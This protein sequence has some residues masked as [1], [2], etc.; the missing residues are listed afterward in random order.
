M[1]KTLSI[2]ALVLFLAIPASSQQILGGDI[3]WTCLNSGP[4][5]GKFVFQLTLF[6]QCDSGAVTATGQSIQLLNGPISNIPLNKLSD[7]NISIGCYD[8][9]KEIKCS[10]KGSGAVSMII[11]RSNPIQLSGTPPAS[12]WKFIWT[13]CCRPLG[14]NLSNSGGYTLRSVMYAYQNQNT[15]TCYDN[16]AQFLG[17]P[18]TRACTG[19]KF[20]SS[21]RPYDVDM[22]KLTF[23]FAEPWDATSTWPGTAMTFK[24]GYSASSPF[25]DSTLNA[26]N[27][28][29][30]I[31]NLSGDI[32]FKSLTV[33]RIAHTIKVSSYRDGQL[34]SEVYRDFLLELT[35]CPPTPTFPPLSNNPPQFVFKWQANSPTNIPLPASDYVFAGDT[36]VFYFASTDV[37]FLPGFIGQTVSTI[38]SGIQFGANFSDPNV[39]CNVAPCATLDTN[40]YY[41]G[42][43][44][45]FEGQ[46]GNASTFTWVPD[47]I[48]GS[49]D[50]NVYNFHFNTYDD[51][52]PIPGINEQ[53]FS[54]VVYNQPD[55]F[56]EG[57]VYGDSN[58]N[59][60]QDAGEAGFPNIIVKQSPNMFYFNTQAN[61]AY[62]LGAYQ[63]AHDV[64][65]VVPKYHNLT[66][67]V[68]GKHTILS[69]GTG[70][71]YSGN[72]FG[73]ELIPNIKDLKIDIHQFW[74]TRPGVDKYYWI[75]YKNTG[76]TTMA[77]VIDM[78]FDTLLN[79]KSSSPTPLSVSGKHILWNFS[80]LKANQ[81]RSISLLFNVD[82]SASVGD[83]IQTFITINPVT[84]DTIPFDN[85]DS[86]WALVTNSYDPNNKRSWPDEL[87]DVK[88]VKA[89]EAI[90][91]TI[92]FQNTGNDKA[93]DVRVVD[94]IQ[95]KLN[96]ET[97]E[98][99]GASHGVEYEIR[100]R[101][102]TFDFKNI[103]LPDSGKDFYGSMGFVKYAIQAD[104]SLAVGD[105]IFNAANIYFDL[106]EPVYTYDKTAIVE[107]TLIDGLESDASRN[108]EPRLTIYPNPTKGSFTIAVKS[109]ENE[110]LQ[111]EMYSITGSLVRQGEFML[112]HSGNGKISLDA[113]QETKGIYFIKVKGSELNLVRK[114][115]IN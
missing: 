39:G 29:A 103:N 1:K 50:G 43:K 65:V 74:P 8:P 9:A 31:L 73:L 40:S 95:E 17:A 89:G 30:Q 96:L 10:S 60:S 37:Q 110:S 99:I 33:N 114:L 68:S 84:G 83:T 32:T 67:P 58:G 27:I 111:F 87:I 26:A 101:K 105:T 47:V 20:N 100:G 86:T 70:N 56:I 24:N 64:S 98:F 77:G 28:E 16:S 6:N 72:D 52:C 35:S 18:N 4:N 91:Y 25:P 42:N 104:T 55:N 49:E 90:E 75:S 71:T 106:N 11:Y 102:I 2:L 46:Y 79:F 15:S 7:D 92:N 23:S 38:P 62:S 82:T 21:H 78:N 12:G 113:S 108:R 69:S 59:G 80:N 63:G 22:D 57:T 81:T 41:K 48:H 76:T 94:W 109:S 36:V 115:I 34:T 5:S 54:V 85:F 44:N 19:Y 66:A 93:I 45:K 53:T 51:W 88:Q 107:D 61:G 3:T 97:F 112:D 13:N 14:S